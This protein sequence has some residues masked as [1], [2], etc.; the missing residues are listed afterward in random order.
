MNEYFEKKITLDQN[1]KQII[2]YDYNNKFTKINQNILV[3]GVAYL[4]GEMIVIHSWK[5]LENYEKLKICNDYKSL[6][7]NGMNADLKMHR[8]KLKNLF[9]K[10]LKIFD[11]FFIWSNFFKSRN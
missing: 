5:I 7:K 1:I 3:I 2:V 8:E 6:I 11:S 10:I 4:K 9:M